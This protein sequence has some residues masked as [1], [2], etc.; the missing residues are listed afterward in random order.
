MRLGRHPYQGHGILSLYHIVLS[1][2]RVLPSRLFRGEINT[3]IECR[4][5]QRQTRAHST[6]GAGFLHR[7]KMSSLKCSEHEERLREVW[8]N[9]AA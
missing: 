8:A 4:E 5:M 9:S 7:P 2:R 3:K 1:Q 6:S